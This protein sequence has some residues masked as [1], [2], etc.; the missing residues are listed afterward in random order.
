MPIMTEKAVSLSKEMSTIK[1]HQIKFLKI[2]T[3]SQIQNSLS[4]L[5][6]IKMTK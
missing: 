6:R 1:R 3:V 5:N 4:R 2:E